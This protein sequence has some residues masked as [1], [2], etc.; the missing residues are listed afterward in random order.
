[1]TEGLLYRIFFVM[2]F[3]LLRFG[4]EKLYKLKGRPEDVGVKI[5]LSREAHRYIADMIATKLARYFTLNY[6]IR[7][8][9]RKF[10]KH[11]RKK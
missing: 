10:K 2:I 1:M 8:K 5:E 4:D 7:R 11:K 9:K 3:R 6:Y